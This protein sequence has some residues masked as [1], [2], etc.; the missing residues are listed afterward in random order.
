MVGIGA[1]IGGL[2][3]F[4]AIRMLF[5]PYK[6]LYIGKWRIPFTPGLIPKRRAELADQIGN[7]VVNHLVTPESIKNKLEDPLFRRDMEKWVNDQLMRWLDSGITVEKLLEILRIDQ[8]LERAGTLIDKGLETKYIQLQERYSDSPMSELIPAEWSSSIESSIPG[9]AEQIRNKASIYFMSEEGKQ[10]IRQLVENFFEDRGKLWNMV[11]MVVGKESI[12]DKLQPELIKFLSN[13]GTK[14]LLIHILESEWAKLQTKT[15]GELLSASLD[16]K[17]IPQLQKWVKD[18]VGLEKLM[19]QPV[20]ALVAAHREK[21]SMSLVPLLFEKA[22]DYLAKQAGD[23]L[24]RLHVETIV[25]EQV[26]SFSLEYLEE[27]V[28]SIAKKELAMITYL[29]AL[30]GGLIGAVQGL[31][32]QFI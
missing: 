1:A 10:K 4:L 31:I 17:L 28:I 22:S 3:N 11:Q 5:R 14:Q 19:K 32:V 15:A 13:P 7:L 24:K 18:A 8:P 20:S 9:V 29:G 16:S 25:K 23:I 12:A 21:L 30:L 6:A 2:T 26:E 27:L